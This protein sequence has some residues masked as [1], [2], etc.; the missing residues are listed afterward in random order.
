[1]NRCDE[2]AWRLNAVFFRDEATRDRG[3]CNATALR[4]LPQHH[5]VSLTTLRIDCKDVFGKERGPRMS[6]EIWSILSAPSVPSL[7][8]A[9]FF[10]V[11]SWHLVGSAGGATLRSHRRAR[12]LHRNTFVSAA[13]AFCFA[14]WRRVPELTVFLI[15]VKLYRVMATLLVCHQLTT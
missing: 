7:S 4:V 13:F 12:A 14:K 5:H 1:L 10:F 6:G 2:R 9:F 11:S 15:Q 3:E 8:R